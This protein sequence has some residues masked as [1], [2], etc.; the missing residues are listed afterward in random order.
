MEMLLLLVF[1]RFQAFPPFSLVVIGGLTTKS[2]LPLKKIHS[3]INFP[4]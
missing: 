2:L 4:F 3:Q 1:A